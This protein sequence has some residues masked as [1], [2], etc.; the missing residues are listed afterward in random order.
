MAVDPGL[1]EMRMEKIRTAP[2]KKGQIEA[3]ASDSYPN[4]P[5]LS[6]KVP[7]DQ[8]DPGCHFLGRRFLGSVAS[9][10]SLATSVEAPGVQ[11]MS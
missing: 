10:I 6:H 7:I 3:G 9:L 8:G 11:I 4:G 2:Q 1:V 5:K